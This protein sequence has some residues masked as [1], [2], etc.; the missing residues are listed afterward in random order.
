MLASLGAV[1][2]GLK[3]EIT[4]HLMK[5]EQVLFPYILALDARAAEGGP[6]PVLHCG[7]IAAPIAQMEHEHE[8]AGAALAKM[9]AITSA[10]ALP[11]DA[12]PT[13]A[14]LFEALQTLEA[15]LH[16]HIHLENNILFPR[17]LALE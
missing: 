5:E 16:A 17:A 6:L 1:F 8:S 13:F 2:A 7:S 3:E 10:Y 9:R 15:D 11:S 4:R 14:A 12:C